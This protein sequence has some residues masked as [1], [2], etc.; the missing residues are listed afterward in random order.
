ME[1]DS[2]RSSKSNTVVD[3]WVDGKMRSISV[4]QAAIGTYLGFDEADVLSEADRCEFVSNNLSMLVIAA[5][6]RLRALG[7]DSDAINLDAGDLPRPDGKSGDR[8]GIE[9]RKGD[10]RKSNQPRPPGMDRRKSDRRQGDRRS[11]PP[12]KS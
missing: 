9:R 6:R 5:G 12:K 8:R 7:G 2:I 11:P 3:M 4:T 1:S 10:R